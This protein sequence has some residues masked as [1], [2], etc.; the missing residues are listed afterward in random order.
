VLTI[1]FHLRI[2]DWEQKY[3]LRDSRPEDLDQIRELK[4]AT[5]RQ[6]MKIKDLIVSGYFLMS[7]IPHKR[8]PNL[9]CRRRRGC[10]SWNL[11]TG[12]RIITRYSMPVQ[13]LASSTL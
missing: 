8:D 2:H 3:A 6:K 10:I 13:V 7:K 11:P 4:E 12:R 5:E 1:L 9:L